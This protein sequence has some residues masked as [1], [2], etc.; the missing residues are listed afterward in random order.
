MV[1]GRVVIAGILPIIVAAWG[2]GGSTPAARGAASTTI[3]W[4]TAPEVLRQ[5]TQPVPRVAWSGQSLREAL[6]GLSR[7]QR[8]AVLL[9]RR[10]DPGQELKIQLDNMSFGIVL[11]EIGYD[12]KL[13]VSRLGPVVYLGPPQ[14][15]ILLW[16]LSVLRID[17]VR[18]MPRAVQRKFLATAPIRWDDLAT[19]RE[20]FEEM[21][22]RSQIR[23][24]GLDRV[25][26]DLWA[27]ADLP[28]MTLINRLTLIAVQYDLTFEIAPDGTSI[29]LVPLPEEVAI[30]RDYPG[31]SDPAALAEKYRKLVPS[32]KVI[33]MDDRIHVTGLM[34][35]HELITARRAPPSNAGGP[36]T[37]DINN[38]RIEKFGVEDKPVGETLREL[39]TM[40]RLDLQIDHEALK[41]AGV[42]LD[43]R[44]SVHVENVK[45][46][47]LLQAIIQ[48]TP[49]RYRRWN[50]VV[51]IT[52]ADGS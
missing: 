30:E 37:V 4:R 38:T 18:P 15:S 19:P 52:P 20:L 12:R 6:R 44:I 43:Q 22:E 13:G 28:P 49:L 45:I 31:G 14:R 48:G 46:D 33:V 42:S 25:P 36:Q 17:D 9:D 29:T 50:N 47:G 32:A 39:A 51:K 26:H 10:V 40:L 35:A 34:E 3:R 2:I 23:I 1:I 7:S 41:K 8:V 24:E 21:A 16:T 27:A 11:E 5:F